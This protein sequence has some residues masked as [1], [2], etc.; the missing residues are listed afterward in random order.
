MDRV[1]DKH[2]CDL[3]AEIKIVSAIISNIT[4]TGENSLIAH[5]EITQEGGISYYDVEYTVEK[6]G[7][8]LFYLS[9]L[10]KSELRST[11]NS[12]NGFSVSAVY[13]VYL[14]EPTNVLVY[15]NPFTD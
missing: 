13:D 8:T 1:S 2:L 5:W 11:Q 4:L 10:C 15:P 3:T 14:G 7:L 6:E 9:I 12:V